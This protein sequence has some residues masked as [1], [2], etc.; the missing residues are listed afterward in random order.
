VLYWLS[1][2]VFE[3]RFSQASV[4]AQLRTRFRVE[5]SSRH[6]LEVQSNAPMLVGESANEQVDASSRD[7]DS[8][9]EVVLEIDAASATL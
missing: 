9:D 5:P 3:R 2:H 7:Y 4:L 1:H 8:D 6:M